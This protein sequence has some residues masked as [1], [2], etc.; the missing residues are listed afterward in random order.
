MSI[1]LIAL[2]IVLFTKAINAIGKDTIAE[3]CWLLY[4]KVSTS[5]NVINLRKLQRKAIDV[6]T[7]KSNTSSKDEFAKW[8]KLDREYTKL[9]T[10]IDGVNGSLNASKSRFKLMVSGV[11]FT[12]TT[13][14]KY[15]LRISYRK[16]PVFWIPD[17]L[18]IPYYVLWIISLPS[19]PLGSVS[20]SVWL[21]AVE[22][23]VSALITLATTMSQY[24]KQTTLGKN[25]VPVEEKSK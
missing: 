2:F 12:S 22:S 23:S 20:I 14:F 17:H 4:T 11:L 13:G 10:Q 18:N 19:A 1:L 7:Q 24:S 21:F 16:N 15:Y 5:Q 8:A 6:Y 3:F 9:K 25:K